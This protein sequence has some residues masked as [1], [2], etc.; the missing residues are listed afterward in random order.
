MYV[1][2]GRLYVVVEREVNCL[3]VS[4]E[5]VVFGVVRFVVVGREV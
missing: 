3:D 4:C 1:I 5:K 2:F